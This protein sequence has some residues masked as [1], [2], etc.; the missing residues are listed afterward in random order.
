MIRGSIQGKNIKTYK[1]LCTQ[2]RCTSIHKVNVIA[3]K[4]EINSHIIIVTL[5]SHLYQ[6]TDHPDR[7]LIRKQILNDTLDQIDLIHGYRTFH[8]KVAEYT[9]FSSVHET[10]FRIVPSCVTYQA[11]LKLRKLKSY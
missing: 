4:W 9:F 7:K 2:H 5:T 10:F 3:I 8:L 6:W 11:S 1:Y